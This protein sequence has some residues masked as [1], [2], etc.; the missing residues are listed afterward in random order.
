MRPTVSTSRP[1][2]RGRRDGRRRPRIV[3]EDDGRRAFRQQRLEQ[4][5]LG[6]V[7]VLDRRVIVHVVAAEIGERAGRKPHAVEPALVEPMA[8]RLHRGVR[9]AF[10]GEFRE[11]AMQRDRIGRGQRAIFVA[12]GSDDAGRADAGRRLAVLLPDLPDEGRDRRLAAGAGDGDH[13]AGLPAEEARR[14]QRQRQPGVVDLDHRDLAC[15]QLRAV[16]RDDCRST[17]SCRISGIGC[18]VGLRAGK[19]EE[20]ETRLNVARV[21]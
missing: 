17:A 13:R 11:Q 12:A 21:G 8:R 19:R 20:Q 1:A 6:F 18:A 14:R 15:G 9:D 5:H 4:P 2:R 7:I 16:C 10:V 3:G